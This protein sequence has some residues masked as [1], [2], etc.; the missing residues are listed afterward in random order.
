MFLIKQLNKKVSIVVI[1]KNENSLSRNKNVIKMIEN[2]IYYFQC[3]G[4][5]FFSKIK[6]ETTTYLSWQMICDNVIC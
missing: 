5:Q 6:T 1:L 4:A 2:P 3:A